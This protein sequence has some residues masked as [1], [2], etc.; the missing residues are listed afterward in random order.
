MA[1]WRAQHVGDRATEELEIALVVDEAAAHEREIIVVGGDPFERPELAR[2]AFAREVVRHERGGL[3]A[4]D[5][6]AMKVFVARESEQV[7]V[8]VADGFASLQRQLV[9]ATEQAGARPVLEAAIA[10]ADCRDLEEVSVERCTASR[11]AA[12]EIDV[13]LA[14]ACKVAREALEIGARAAGE[15]DFVA[16]AAGRE[17]GQR[18]VAHLDRV[19]DERVVAL[20]AIAAEAVRGGAVGFER[21]RDAPGRVRFRRRR[22]DVERA[23]SRFTPLGAQEHARTVEV[24]ARRIEVGGAHG[25]VERIDPRDD[26]QRGARRRRPP[27]VL[28]L[29]AQRDGPAARLRA[30]VDELT[31]EFAYQIA[32]GNPGR[33][34][35]ALPARLRGVDRAA[36]FEEVRVRVERRNAVA[37][38]LHA[39]AR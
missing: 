7:E 12:E 36:Y 8:A 31:G 22:D 13:P 9:A 2:V 16:H 30:H 14:D 23:G 21:G 29:L 24:G 38:C 1:P 3:D 27:D 34:A 32:A 37:G 33:Q 26:G 39:A 25:Q 10:F 17:H 28:R 5:V 11:R 4:L 35:E 19:V 15:R 20:G 6:P 18:E